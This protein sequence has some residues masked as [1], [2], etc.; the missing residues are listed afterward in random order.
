MPEGYGRFRSLA[1]RRDWCEWLL[2]ACLTL[3]FLLTFFKWVGLYPAGYAAYTQNAWQA[4]FAGLSVDP[5][6]EKFL[7]HE[8]S[9]ND[10]LHASWW[11]LPYLILVVFAFVL[12]W[13]ERVAK[14]MR[15]KVPPMMQAMGKMRP[16]LLAAC[17]GLTLVLIV[18]QCVSGFSLEKAVNSIAEESFKADREKA[19]TPEE[20]QDVDMKVATVK[21]QYHYRTTTWLTLTII[22]HFLAFGA[23]IS[24]TMLIHRGDKPPPRIGIMW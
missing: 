14:L 10:R 17:A 9:I 1:L 13:G 7:G 2:P 11:L 5:V 19:K 23:C 18:I 12:T 4:L 24:D 15:W 16:A 3:I 22:L 6:S 8:K 20:I 21:A